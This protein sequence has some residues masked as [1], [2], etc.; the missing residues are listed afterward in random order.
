MRAG[1]GIVIL[2][3]L[4]AGPS[5]LADVVYTNEV[6]S[7]SS[8]Q[9]S[10][11]GGSWGQTFT[12]TGPTAKIQ[13]VTVYLRNSLGATGNLFIRIRNISGTPPAAVLGTVFS[14]QMDSNTV[15]VGGNYSDLS[16]VTFNFTDPT[17]ADL[18]A[19]TTY[20][21]AV[22]A[23]GITGEISLFYASTAIN[24]QNSINLATNSANSTLD[25]AGQV[26]TV[27]EPGTLVLGGTAAALGG[28]FF[29]Q[30]KTGW[31]ITAGHCLGQKNAF[32]S[33][34]SNEILTDFIGL[35]CH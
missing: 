29:R 9:I 13:S 16:A 22:N 2:F 12:N 30:K 11:A 10:L 1:L 6:N 21:F 20:A 15:S 3:I 34:G 7:S 33:F 17:R 23:T 31:G 26:V 35:G 5:A 27:P 19:N 4:S 25:L 24:N 14:P 18:V 28:L 8:A 32:D